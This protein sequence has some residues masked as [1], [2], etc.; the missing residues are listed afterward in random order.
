AAATATAMAWRGGV[1]G[2]SRR[3][4]RQAPGELLRQPQAVRRVP[5][6]PLELEAVGRAEARARLLA[7]ASGQPAAL[8]DLA[9]LA[10]ACAAA[11]GPEAARASAGAGGPP[12]PKSR[13]LRDVDA[14]LAELQRR[15]PPRW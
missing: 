2:G 7:A 11:G 3:S 14:G 6:A 5:G 15:L 1:G 4:A 10:A 9:R 8:G 13:A 12:P